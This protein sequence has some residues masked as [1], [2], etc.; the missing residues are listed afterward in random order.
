L[1]LVVITFGFVGKKAFSYGG[2]TAPGKEL[3]IA[4]CYE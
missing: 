1:N 3:F 4:A 2:M